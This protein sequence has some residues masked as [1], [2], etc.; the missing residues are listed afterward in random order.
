M[1]TVGRPLEVLPV[2]QR[3]HGAAGSAHEVGQLTVGDAGRRVAGG[4]VVHSGLGGE[5]LVPLGE[6]GVVAVLV[7]VLP[8]AVADDQV[9]DL[10]PVGEV[11]EAVLDGRC[12]APDAR[13]K[14]PA[15]GVLTKK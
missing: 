2:A 6:H 11:A 8:E 7:Q 15:W 4:G 14:L 5:H 12:H 10:E 9:L 1:C 13:P 3:A